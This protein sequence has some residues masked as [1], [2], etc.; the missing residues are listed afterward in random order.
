MTIDTSIDSKTIEALALLA[1]KP[2]QGYHYLGLVKRGLL[3]GAL[4][5][6]DVGLVEKYLIEGEY[7]IEARYRIT[8]IGVDYFNKIKE[9]TSNLLK[10]E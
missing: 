7:E 6:T 1:R 4:E 2:N 9:Y 3:G 8:G 10:K 5:L